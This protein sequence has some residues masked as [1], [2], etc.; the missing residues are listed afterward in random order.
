MNLIDALQ[1]LDT[2]GEM[3]VFPPNFP[4]KTS[5]FTLNSTSVLSLFHDK[6]VCES[7]LSFL[8]VLAIYSCAT[9]CSSHFL[10]LLVQLIIHNINSHVISYRD[11]FSHFHIFPLFHFR[12]DDVRLYTS[13]SKQVSLS[14]TLST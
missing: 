8:F 14:A 13:L 10:L 7:R 9:L 11:E 1:A 3:L 2:S 12:T 5:Q 4:N 6:H